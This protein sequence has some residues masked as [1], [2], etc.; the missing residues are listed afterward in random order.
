M[1]KIFCVFLSYF[2]LTCGQP[3][4]NGTS[5]GIFAIYLLEDSTLSA[6][7]VYSL[8]IESLI[9]SEKAFFSANEL[10]S[11]SWPSHS[12][13]LNDQKRAEYENFALNSGSTS[14]IPFIVTVGE[15]RIYFG[16]FWWAYSSSLPPACAVIDAIGPLPYRIQ[17]VTGAI[18]ERNDLRIYNS[19][20]S[21]GVLEL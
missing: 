21:S 15:E 12:F 7:D 19:L 14:G 20:K 1:K 8:S 18:D 16:T 11:Y 9:L 17:L 13:E 4:S 2:L 10:I 5:E 6:S 3:T